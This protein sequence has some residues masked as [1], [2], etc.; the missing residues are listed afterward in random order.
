M[1]RD[2]RDPFDRASM[3]HGPADTP[4]PAPLPPPDGAGD[5]AAWERFLA[6]ARAAHPVPASLGEP[7]RA[8]SIA[9][10]IVARVRRE[11]RER[12]AA[13]AT[14]RTP[15]VGPSRSR[16]RV[17]WPRLVAASLG[18]HAAVLAALALTA[19]R[20]PEARVEPFV[21]AT[22]VA[23]SSEP[24]ALSA[25]PPAERPFFDGGMA[26]RLPEWVP[27]AL[28][29]LDL[30]DPAAGLPE[31]GPSGVELAPAPPLSGNVPLL[32]GTSPAFR[33]RTDD[34]VKRAIELR[35][36]VGGTG[37]TV[38]RTLAALAERQRI[39]GTFPGAA[40]DPDAPTG[41]RSLDVSDAT[42]WTLLA[43]LG[44]GHCSAFGDY[45]DVVARGVAALRARR[46][47]DR[48]PLGGPVVL[49]A[50]AEDQW[51]ASG[52]R[53]P[54]ENRAPVADLRVLAARWG[55]SSS[56]S[57]SRDAVLT[58]ALAAAARLRIVEAPERTL[59]AAHTVDAWMLSKVT[60]ETAFERGTA[61]AASGDVATFRRWTRE[62][63]GT[64][65]A[66]LDADGLAAA[67]SGEAL[68]DGA[69]VPTPSDLEALRVLR[70]AKALL[71]LQVPFRLE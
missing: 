60:P 38:R 14:G 58:A 16:W 70:T 64:L 26:D 31:L 59:L 25:L 33:A 49:W 3:S 52:F 20:E 29:G 28:D 18:A 23:W 50:L 8:A 36:E 65:L 9:A 67:P 37:K 15:A 54:A 17:L 6:A 39:D 53:T 7:A 66:T 42:A 2:P 69:G 68:G 12:V 45:R 1:N 56:S 13:P 19:R 30:R 5:A 41:A 21:V 24:E 43:F 32:R 27:P 46:G 51:L 4:P 71:G 10:H 61:L 22:S 40:P 63:V 47:P 62:A 35:L 55:A 57:S 48:A 11:E 44:D 34:R